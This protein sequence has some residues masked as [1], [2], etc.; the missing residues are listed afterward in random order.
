MHAILI[1]FLFMLAIFGMAI[2][3]VILSPYRV[4][5][6]PVEECAIYLGETFC[7]LL[8]SAIGY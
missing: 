3:I 7:D 1:G 2:I 8:Y 4:P 5:E 6:I